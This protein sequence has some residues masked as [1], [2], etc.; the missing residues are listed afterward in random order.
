MYSELPRESQWPSTVTCVLVH[1]FIQSAFLCSGALRIVA[2]RRLVEIEED[3]VERL[4]GVQLIQR[5]P[6]EDLL[7]GERRGSRSR[8]AA[9]AAAAVAAAAARER[10]RGGGGGGGSG[11]CGGTF[12]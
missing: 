6:R 7:L 3:V 9:A 12:L 4:L 10:P 5:L 8:C 1:L 11:A 2:D